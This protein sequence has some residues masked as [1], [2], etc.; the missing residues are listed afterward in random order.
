MDWPT[1]GGQPS[2]I[3]ELTNNR[4]INMVY[5]FSANINPLGP[6]KI[7]I[8]AYQEAYYSL[9]VYPDPHYEE[10][11]TCITQSL[12]VSNEQVLM[13]NGGAE[14]IFLV[15]QQ[16]AGQ[17]AIIVE[18]TFSEYERACNVYNLNVNRIL[19]D[20]ENNFAF[21]HEKI[22]AVMEKVDV[23]FICNPNNPTGTVISLSEIRRLCK[24]AQ[25]TNTY[26][27]I[28]E[29]FFHFL[30]ND[31]ESASKL[32]EIYPNLIILHSLTKMFA[33][34]SLRIGYILADESLISAC[35]SKQIPWSINGVAAKVLPHLVADIDFV[36]ETRKW[37]NKELLFLKNNLEKLH[38]YVS[39]TKVNFYLLKDLKQQNDTEA[40]F[41]FLVEHGI[42]PRHT[43]NFT[44]LDNQFI[45]LAVRTKK[46]NRYLLKML[47][48]WRETI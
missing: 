44:G 46:E 13:T 45:R 8:S 21:P 35:K 28:D 48:K 26:I 11:H 18:P 31:Y 15:A 42:I 7:I 30:P 40:L 12:G 3:M 6:P 32:I 41:C 4:N 36:K 14:A 38:F 25:K 43:R 29:A 16:F 22:L 5:D 9:T 17:D 34:P 37:L 19:L 23:V 33:I 2:K 10:L 20:I 1:H 27:V 47:T 39:P 24:K